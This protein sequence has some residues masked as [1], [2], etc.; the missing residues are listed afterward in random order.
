MIVNGFSFKMSCLAVEWR[1]C[2]TFQ[3]TKIGLFLILGFEVVAVE[4]VGMCG[5]WTP[6]E[7]G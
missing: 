6:Q 7:C 3:K 2:L 5:G 1:H 4:K